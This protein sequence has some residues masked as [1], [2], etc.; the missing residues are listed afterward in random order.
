MFGLATS[1]GMKNF[2]TFRV[3]S[4]LGSLFILAFASFFV[5]LLF[6]SMKNYDSELTSNNSA[7][8]SAYGSPRERSVMNQ[9]AE[10]NNINAPLGPNRVR[11]FLS[12][13]PDRPWL[14]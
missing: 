13:Y 2:A 8:A 11:W 1:Y 5:G 7:I 6:V 3:E 12:N 9:W 4:W 14:N 10:K